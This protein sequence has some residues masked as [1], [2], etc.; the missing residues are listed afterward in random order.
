MSEAETDRRVTRL[1]AKHEALETYLPALLNSM[2][3]TQDE[4]RTD[5][6]VTKDEVRRSLERVETSV[7]FTRAERLALIVG[8]FAIA[9]TLAANFFAALAFS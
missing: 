1:E 5:L 2:Q 3:R 6:R 7:R 8:L 4:I 9:A